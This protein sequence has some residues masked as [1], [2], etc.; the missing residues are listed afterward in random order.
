MES[1][2]PELVDPTLALSCFLITGA[3]GTGKTTLLYTLALDLA[4]DF[5]IP[6]LIH[7][8]S[9]P[10]DARVLGSLVKEKE[11][12]RIV[13]IIRHASE[14]LNEIERF[15]EDLKHLKYPVTLLLEE[16]KNQW[17]YAYTSKKINPVEFELSTL[18]EREI[19]NILESLQKY[20]LLGKLTGS[21][22]EYQISHFTELA[23][24]ELIIALRELTTEGK[25][26]TIIKNEYDNIPTDIAKKAY[27]YVAALS[28]IDLA[29][30]YETIIRILKVSTEQL[31][32]DIFKPTEG[33]LISGE[34]SGNSR[35]NFGF[36]LRTRHPIIA[37]IIFSL[38]T[39]DDKAKFQILN[40]IL[41]HLDPGFHEDKYLLNEIVKHRELVNTFASNE[42]KRA[43]YERLE[44][45]LPE[46]P[47]VMQH[48]S[49]LERELGDS[50]QSVKYAR[51]AIEGDRN[52]ATFKNTL[53][54]ALEL[55]ARHSKEELQRKALLSEASRLFDEGIKSN[56]SDAY[57]YLGKY[58]IKRNE[59]ERELDPDK[60]SLMEAEVLSYLDIA[61]ELTNE[62]EI[63]AAQ[64]ASQKKR[65]GDNTNAIKILTKAM[66]DNPTNTRIRDLLIIMISNSNPETALGIAIEG[67]RLDPTSWRLYRHIARIMRMLNKEPNAIA[68]N[69]EAAIRHNRSDLNLMVEYASYLFMINRRPE[70]K[71]IFNQ[72]NNLSLPSQLKSKVTEWWKD[73]KGK[74]IVFTGNVTKILGI[75]AWVR[76]VPY[77]FEA[78]FWRTQSMLFSLNEG[79][80]VK[81]TVGF[82]AHGP[83]A[84]IV[85]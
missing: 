46:N 79:D 48:R 47:Y 62:S 58:S 65:L 13:V 71:E 78:F 7:I 9:T 27:L 20:H 50:E 60:K 32:K 36:R 54:L 76:V 33:V 84:R 82:N 51:R 39:T 74:Y 44:N 81:F 21:P 75:R 59:I 69:Y 83:L 16:R 49:I 67:V 57:G 14:Y 53:G 29:I 28:Q 10:L 45:I 34:V 85:K 80:K 38:G 2:F 72:A 3:A 15:L 4:Q 31:V 11:P 35:H 8:P 17:K 68:G 37:S 19:V 12:M 77:G 43:I 64:L 52:N 55:A 25:F 1:L 24:K 63:I 26:D 22:R 40:D 42:N 23:D 66:A 5:D 73:D 30:R 70:A 61:Y 56:P 41:T 6:V 18:S